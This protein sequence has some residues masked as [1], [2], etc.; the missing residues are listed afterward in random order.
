[1]KLSINIISNF[2]GRVW[3]AGIG[4]ILVPQYIKFLGVESY[5][6]VGFYGTL[7]ASMALLD[8]GLSTTLNREL[9]K[10]RVNNVNS[11]EVRDLVYTLELIYFLI[12]LLIASAVIILAP[13]IAT[14]WINA[15][16]LSSDEITSAVRLMGIIVAFQWPISLYNGGLLGIDKQ[17]VDNIIMVIMTTIRSAGVILILIFVSPTIKAFFIWQAII[18]LIYVLTMRTGLWHYLPKTPIKATFSRGQLKTIWRFAAGMTSIGIISFFLTQIDKVVLSKVLPLS[19]YAYYTLAF[20]VS[21]GIGMF[22]APINTAVFPRLTALVSANDTEGLINAY[23]KA[24]K[25]IASIVFPIGLVLMFF[26]NDILLIWTKNPVTVTHIALM[27]QI[28]VAGSIINSLMIVPYLLLLANGQTRFTFNQNLIAAIALV[29]L[30]F[31]WVHLYGALGGTFVWL[32]VNTGSLLISIPLI[33]NKLLKGE[34]KN[35]YINDTF[36]PLIP[37]LISIIIIKLIVNK[38]SE[39]FKINFAGIVI[40]FLLVLFTSSFFIPEVRDFKKRIKALF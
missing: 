10:A 21:G 3:V 4:I 22:T 31:W 13:L 6:L 1:L 17:V 37:N 26:V 9:T 15:E 24:C 30:L 8:F 19:Q 27:V 35:W 33:H 36:L 29:P 40:I 2:I 20:T 25:L 11:K 32:A 14:H 12:G 38:Y 23:H 7:I 5:G 16:H 18:S 28:L 39:I 34:L